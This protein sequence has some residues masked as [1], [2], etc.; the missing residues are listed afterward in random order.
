MLPISMYVQTLNSGRIFAYWA[1]I[2]FVQFFNTKATKMFGCI[3]TFNKIYVAILT[4]NGVGSRFG[5]FF[6]N[7]F[8]HP[9]ELLTGHCF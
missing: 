3:S 1:I 6:T 7:S 9:V 8:G 4:K 5:Q 2:Y